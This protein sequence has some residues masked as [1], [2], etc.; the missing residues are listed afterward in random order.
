M[1]LNLSRPAYKDAE[2]TTLYSIMVFE[3]KAVLDHREGD[4]M[5][6]NK[7]YFSMKSGFLYVSKCRE[8]GSPTFCRFNSWIDGGTLV[9]D[10]YNHPLD[11]EMDEYFIDDLCEFF[12]KHKF[13]SF[14]LQERGAGFKNYISTILPRL[15][16]HSHV[17]YRNIPDDYEPYKIMRKRYFNY[18][19]YINGHV[20]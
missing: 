17:I 14:S 1:R 7:T 16:N 19:D 12:L 6:N 13:T 3:S 8:H 15:K 18:I 10:I 11:M 20:N 9:V 2:D 5:F 4:A